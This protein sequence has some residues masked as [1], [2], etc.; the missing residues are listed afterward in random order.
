MLNHLGR[1]RHNTAQPH[2]KLGISGQGK[3]PVPNF[4]AENADQIPR[5][6]QRTCFWIVPSSLIWEA[7]MKYPVIAGIALLFV[8]ST[9]A[10]AQ[11][12]ERDDSPYAES[13]ADQSAR[14]GEQSWRDQ[15]EI[16]RERGYVWQGYDQP[17]YGYIYPA[18]PQYYQRDARG[19]YYGPPDVRYYGPPYYEEPGYS[20]NPKSGYSG[21]DVNPDADW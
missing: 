3:K 5:Q 14:G 15:N 21:P 8:S 11:Y 18:P 20:P 9:A 7:V 6:L 1:L 4:S 19:D 2:H 16:A 10:W 17:G 13:Y 12:Y